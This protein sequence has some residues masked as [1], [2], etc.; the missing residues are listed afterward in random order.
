MSV[1]VRVLKNKKYRRLFFSTDINNSIK[2]SDI[3]FICVGTPNKKK[4]NDS[5]SGNDDFYNEHRC[6][7][8]EQA[9]NENEYGSA[10]RNPFHSL[11][12]K[13]CQL[14]PIQQQQGGIF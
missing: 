2:Q 4:S 5:D 12:R 13:I 7:S 1:G 14:Q 10:G 3:I 8:T 6:D 9:T 11:R